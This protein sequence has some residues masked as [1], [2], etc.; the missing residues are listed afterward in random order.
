M[1]DS[2]LRSR[3]AVDLQSTVIAAIRTQHMVVPV[4]NAP[5]THGSSDHCSTFELQNLGQG[6]KNR[7][8][9]AWAQAIRVAITLHPAIWRGYKVTLPAS[10]VWKP[11]TA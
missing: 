7:T 6:R 9:V 2:N 10:W 5:T 3:K 4:G 8:F 11:F 1:K